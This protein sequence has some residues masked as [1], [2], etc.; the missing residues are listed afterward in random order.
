MINKI[1]IN[2][3]DEKNVDGYIPPR[4]SYVTSEPHTST[5]YSYQAR[6]LEKDKSLHVNGAYGSSRSHGEARL[7]R[8]W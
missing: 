5:R 4:A 8:V 2:K 3:N 7:Q 6:C 1:M